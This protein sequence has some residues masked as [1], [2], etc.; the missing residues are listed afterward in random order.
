[1][2]TAMYSGRRYALVFALGV[3][4]GATVWGM[5]AAFGLAAV[6]A[7]YSHA[8]IAMKVLGGL[9]L[10]WFSFKSARSA[11]AKRLPADL[12]S[13][14]REGSM[15][16]V[17]LRGAGLMA[18]WLP[19]LAMPVFGCW[20]LPDRVDS[21]GTRIGITQKFGRARAGARA[22]VIRMTELF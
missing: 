18:Y 5:L 2:A 9:Y 14:V 17:Y 3:V 13:T 1:M 10:L 11:L 16:S 20:H 7:Q 22:S 15:L 4:S 19:S 21:H 12:E 8:L 6:M